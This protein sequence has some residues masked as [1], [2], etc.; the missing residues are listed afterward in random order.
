[1]VR[2]LVYNMMTRELLD[3]R[4]GVLDTYIIDG[5]RNTH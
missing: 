4:D 5:S 2:D 1:M 3:G